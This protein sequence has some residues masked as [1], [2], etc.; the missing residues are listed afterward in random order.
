MAV[1]QRKNGAHAQKPRRR[2]KSPSRRS[3]RRPDRLAARARG[4]M[5][6]AVRPDIAAMQAEVRQLMTDLEDRIER[7]NMLT[8]RGAEHAVDGVNE[9]VVGAVT[10][11]T[12]LVRESAETVTDDATK[13]SSQA[14]REVAAQIDKRPLLTLAIAAGI[15]FIAG[16]VRRP[17]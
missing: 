16:L 2:S 13:F 10:G 9:L 15:G 14:I 7:L 8:K 5:P 17:D 3:A 6:K 11:A 4:V 12:K 1:P